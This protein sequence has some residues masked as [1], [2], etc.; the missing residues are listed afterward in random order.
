MSRRKREQ[1]AKLAADVEAFLAGGG[2]VSEVDHTANKTYRDR[3]KH[4]KRA[5]RSG[6]GL[7][8]MKIKPD[9]VW[10]SDGMG[11]G[12]IGKTI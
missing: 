2:S 3:Q 1:S 5:G 7:H 10:H 8:P 4:L 12:A 11:V 6:R 9:H